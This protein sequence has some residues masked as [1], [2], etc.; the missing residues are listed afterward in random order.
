MLSIYQNVKRRAPA[1]SIAAKYVSLTVRRRTTH[2]VCR[3]VLGSIPERSIIRDG[4]LWPF[5]SET[6]GYFVHASVSLGK[7]LRAN[8]H[9]DLS[10]I[11]P[12]NNFRRQALY[13]VGQNYVH[14]IIYTIYCIPNFGPPCIKSSK[15]GSCRTEYSV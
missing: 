15:E 11:S 7:S 1:A 13:R 5:F 4:Q 9:L 2:T 10:Q 3:K 6:V 12:G 14:S 8:L